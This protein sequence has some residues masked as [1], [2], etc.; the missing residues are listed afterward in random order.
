MHPQ[1]PLLDRL[2]TARDAIIAQIAER[3][4]SFPD[5]APQPP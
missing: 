2:N 4:R 3:D 5:M 1:A